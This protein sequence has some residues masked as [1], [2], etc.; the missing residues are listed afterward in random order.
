MSYFTAFRETLYLKYHEGCTYF[1]TYLSAP[2]IIIVTYTSLPH[3]VTCPDSFWWFIPSLAQPWP[4]PASLATSMVFTWYCNIATTRCKPL[5]QLKSR[6]LPG[7]YNAFTADRSPNLIVFVF[8]FASFGASVYG[9][10][11]EKTSAIPYVL[12]QFCSC[13]VLKKWLSVLFW[14][15]RICASKSTLFCAR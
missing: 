12:R 14:N 10:F 5:Q 11:Y 6:Y 15:G 1:C 8:G 4:S 9:T 13:R 3:Y 7:F 2:D